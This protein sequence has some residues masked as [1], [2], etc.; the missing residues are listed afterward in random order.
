MIQKRK[1]VIKRASEKLG[2]KPKISLDEGLVK[3]INYYKFM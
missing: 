2:W 3:T 1:P